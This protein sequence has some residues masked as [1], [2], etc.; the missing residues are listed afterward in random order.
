MLNRHSILSALTMIQRMTEWIN[1][2]SVISV[3]LSQI[4]IHIDQTVANCSVAIA[5]KPFKAEF[6]FFC[7]DEHY[8]HIY[9]H[10]CILYS[11]CRLTFGV[12]IMVLLFSML[13]TTFDFTFV[14]HDSYS[15]ADFIFS[16]KN[17]WMLKR[18]QSPKHSFCYFPNLVPWCS[19][20]SFAHFLH[21]SKKILL[22]HQ[23]FYL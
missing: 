7:K 15:H 20:P 21:V 5:N 12:I 8:Y 1:E 19:C 4:L 14:W 10:A 6:R 13:H 2:K 9:Y 18:N 17:E 11:F 3:S 22:S 16:D 23:C